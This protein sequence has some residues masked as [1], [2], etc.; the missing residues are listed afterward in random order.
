MAP[1]DT[2]DVT[3]WRVRAPEESALMTLWWLGFRGGSAVLIGGKSLAHAR[4]LAAANELGRPSQFFEGFAIDPK[5]ANLIPQGSIFRKLPPGEAR[6]LINLVK[7][8]GRKHA[9][10]QASK[11]EP[12]SLTSNSGW[13][14]FAT[15]AARRRVA[16]TGL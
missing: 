13:R 15:G 4:L 8:G 5:L 16:D 1:A 2:A 3:S 10:G 6:E 11:P 12:H 7:H 14:H 9:A